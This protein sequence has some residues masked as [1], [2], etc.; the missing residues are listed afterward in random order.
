MRLPELQAR[1]TAAL[2]DPAAPL[3]PIAARGLTAARR[4]AVYRNNAFAAR[5]GAL[6]AIYPVTERL[7]GAECFSA[8]AQR[9]LAARPPLRA[10]LRTL[11]RHLPAFCAAQAE[12]A[13]L[14]YLRDVA[15]LEWA[16]HRAF[17]APD[18]PL[19]AAA[20]LAGAEPER[21]HLRAH[22]ASALIASRFPVRDIWQANQDGADGH[23][24]LRRGAQNVLVTRPRL[25]VELR[26][27]RRGEAAFARALARGATLP[28]AI[29]RALA[30]ERAFDPAATLPAL[31]AAG[32]WT[33]RLT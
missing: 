20:D 9:Y 17:H 7:L 22:P 5:R 2:R 13:H 14:P 30:A 3:P 31:L 12:F 23:A 29:T 4:L 18:A 19:L 32:A 11:G 15:R 25:E 6:A 33:A 16:W 28:D 21:L 1:F 26:P 24:D 8:L 27:L 10:D